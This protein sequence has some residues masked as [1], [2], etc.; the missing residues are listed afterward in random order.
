MTGTLGSST[1][2]AVLTF[3]RLRDNFYKVIQEYGTWA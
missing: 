3:E 2:G 1:T